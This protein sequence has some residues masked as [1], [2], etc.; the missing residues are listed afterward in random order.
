MTMDRHDTIGAMLDEYALGQLSQDER[1]NVETHIREC[2]VCATDLRH[3]TVVME[4]IAHSVDPVTPPP[5]LKQRVLA[6]L[7]LQPQEP[8]RAAVESN[9]VT[10]PVTGVKIRRGVHPGWLAAAAVV[11]L[12]L[13]VALYSSDATRRLLIDDVQEAQAAAVD[14]QRRIDLYAEQADLAVSILTAGDMQPIAMSGK[15]DATASTARAYWSRTRGLL[16]VADDLPVPPPGRVYQVWVI[17]GGTPFSAGL[18][19]DQGAGRGMLI[20]PPPNGVAPG[21]ITVA[22]TDEPPG[23]LPAP[24]GMIRLAGSI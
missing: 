6:S 9:V 15:E 17:G 4:G 23:G 5:A 24:S 16:I 3:L 22:V 2:D 21:T 8:R 20:A 13:G 18:L 1:R 12:G 10:M 19:G 14:L 7:A 11:I